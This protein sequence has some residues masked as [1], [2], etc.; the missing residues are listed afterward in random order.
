MLNLRTRYKTAT[1]RLK[2]LDALPELI[3]IAQARHRPLLETKSTRD[4][5]RLSLVTRILITIPSRRGSRTAVTG[6]SCELFGSGVET[7]RESASSR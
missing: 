6:V 7:F 4:N 2:D 3:H 1:A 5:L